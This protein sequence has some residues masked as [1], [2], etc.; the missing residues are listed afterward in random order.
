MSGIDDVRRF[1][2][3]TT[4]QEPPKIGPRWPMPTRCAQMSPRGLRADRRGLPS[5]PPK[6]LKERAK[7]IRRRPP[8][9]CKE[10]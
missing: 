7:K 5:R 1:T 9:R 8:K 10:P 4:A 3:S 6:A 2:A